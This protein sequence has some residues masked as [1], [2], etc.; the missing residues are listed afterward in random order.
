M[1]GHSGIFA[2]HT[3]HLLTGA[4]SVSRTL[5]FENI[6]H[7]AMPGDT[8]TR[9]ARETCT[10]LSA[11]FRVSQ[12]GDVVWCSTR[13]HLLLLIHL[14]TVPCSIWRTA[15]HYLAQHV[16]VAPRAVLT[17]NIAMQTAVQTVESSSVCACV[18]VWSVRPAGGVV[19]GRP[20]ARARAATRQLS[21]LLVDAGRL[22]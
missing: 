10:F 6:E 4:G 9:M 13:N 20:A 3:A 1:R 14:C 21:T 5:R 8:S 17:A 19:C 15:L 11:T 2:A 22:F 16:H 18:V 12:G 7:G